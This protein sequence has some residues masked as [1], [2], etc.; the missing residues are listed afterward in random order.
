ML[1]S[2][3]EFDKA[4]TE[5]AHA[6]FRVL[7]GNNDNQI[8]LEELQRAEQIITDQIERL[9]VPEPANSFRARSRTGRPQESVSPCPSERWGGSRT[10]VPTTRP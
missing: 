3:A 7:D 4:L 6:A 5:P 9:R 1:L 8:S 10:A 2:V